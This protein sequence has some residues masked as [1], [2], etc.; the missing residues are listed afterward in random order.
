MTTI[1]LKGE[2]VRH[3]KRASWGI[4][5]IVSVDRCGTIQVVFEGDR[6]VSI[7]KGA[8]FLVKAP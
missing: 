3:N 8:K 7:A 1:L 6:T 5:K 2:K 4:G